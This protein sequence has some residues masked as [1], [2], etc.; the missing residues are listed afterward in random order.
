[1][2]IHSSASDPGD[3]T[4]M[5]QTSMI[6]HNFPRLRIELARDSLKSF[7]FNCINYCIYIYIYIVYGAS[8]YLQMIYCDCD[9][10]LS[11]GFLV[12]TRTDDRSRNNLTKVVDKVN[13]ILR[14]QKR[15]AGLA[16]IHTTSDW[17]HFQLN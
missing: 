7:Y 8:P 5:D 4:S 14:H 6:Y 12:A 10:T 16:T 1:M 2:I 15:E 13:N 11:S 17:F 9:G 3:Q